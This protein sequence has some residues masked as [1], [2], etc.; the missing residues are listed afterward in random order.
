MQ[1]RNVKVTKI[2]A[3]FT[4]MTERIYV[5]ECVHIY[6]MQTHTQLR[7]NSYTLDLSS[8]NFVDSV[9]DIARTRRKQ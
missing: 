9:F 2:L 3:L 5:Y 6:P 8:G 4:C 7:D 1:L